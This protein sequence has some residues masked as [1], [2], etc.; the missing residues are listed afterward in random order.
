MNQGEE[1]EPALASEQPVETK[2]SPSTESSNEGAEETKEVSMSEAISLKKEKEDTPQE[3]KEAEPSTEP[4]TAPTPVP[5]TVG[6]G[7]LTQLGGQAYI[8]DG[9]SLK[10]SNVT[11]NGWSKNQ[12]FKIN[13]MEYTEGLGFHIDYGTR[14]NMNIPAV[15]Y[16]LGGKFTKLTGS[17]GIDDEFL[18][19]GSQ[20]RVDFYVQNLDNSISLLSSTDWIKAG[21]FAIP[22]EIDVT[23][24]QMLIIEMVK[25]DETDDEIKLALVDTK[26]E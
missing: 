16:P 20:Y 5:S 22:F 7:S 14:T 3:T 15:R 10:E 19:S 12:R 21:N 4:A 17:I 2:D 18:N 24:V 23:G 13:G 1:K 6:L 26:F 11:M 8:K 25:N 9:G